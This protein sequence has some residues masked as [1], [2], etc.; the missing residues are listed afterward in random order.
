MNCSTIYYLVQLQ[1]AQSGG[2][3]AATTKSTS[4]R[5]LTCAR[6]QLLDL[7]LFL[8]QS[9]SLSLH[10][11]FSL[12]LVLYNDDSDSVGSVLGDDDGLVYAKTG[13]AYPAT[14]PQS[15][16]PQHPRL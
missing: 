4:G 7:S 15:P 9:L 14:S 13:P 6:P 2:K 8:P 11:F 5:R 16:Q 12:F 10:S 1:K 3:D